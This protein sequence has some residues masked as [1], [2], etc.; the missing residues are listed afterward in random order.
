MAGTIIGETKKE[1]QRKAKR[2][3]ARRNQKKGERASPSHGRK[4]FHPLSSNVNYMQMK[5]N[6][7]WTF[8]T[9]IICQRNLPLYGKG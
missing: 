7:N 9:S 8:R 3:I 4:L 5:S 1:G 6:N 2:H